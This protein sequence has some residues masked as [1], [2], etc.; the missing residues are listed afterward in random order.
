MGGQ[1]LGWDLGNPG[2]EPCH[3]GAI[4]SSPIIKGCIILCLVERV[5][6]VGLNPDAFGLK[7]VQ[8]CKLDGAFGVSMEPSRL[9]NTRC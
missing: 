4:A 9:Q 3:L 5:C 2:S 8:I 1:A 6:S 7:R